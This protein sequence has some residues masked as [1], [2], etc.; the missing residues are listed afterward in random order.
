MVKH[1][2]PPAYNTKAGGLI[3]VWEIVLM[4]LVWDTVGSARTR[5]REK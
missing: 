3:I 1:T 5:T 2:K 4:K